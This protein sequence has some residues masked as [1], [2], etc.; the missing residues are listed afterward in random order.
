MK[1]TIKK[2]FLGGEVTNLKIFLTNKELV[3]TQIICWAQEHVDHYV[4]Q[5]SLRTRAPLHNNKKG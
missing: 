1:Y 4:V 3:F 2:V 5:I